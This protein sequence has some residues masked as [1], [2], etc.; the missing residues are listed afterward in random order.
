MSK[1]RMAGDK[2]RKLRKIEGQLK[3]SAKMH[4]EQADIIEGIIRAS[5]TS[6]A[7]D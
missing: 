6:T 2:I 1:T 7:A 5:D 4:K 3:N